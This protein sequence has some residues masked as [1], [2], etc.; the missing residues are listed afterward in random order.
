LTEEAVVVVCPNPRCRREFEEP[1]LLTI[2]S[3]TPPKQYEACPCCFANLEQEALIEQKEV[4]EPTIKQ[5]IVPEPTVEQGE[6]IEK[7][8]EKE[9]T[10][11]LSVNAVLEKVKDSG[12]SFFKKFKSLIPS[13]SGLK[14]EKKEKTKEPQAEPTV[15]E[16]KAPKEKPKNRTECQKRGTE[17]RAIRQQRRRVVRLPGS[18]RILG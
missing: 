11:N 15:K 14:K 1:I 6:T 17:T 3:V 10:A 9:T 5:K 8:E 16:E 12:P 7:G 18:F 13:T 2:L 4:L